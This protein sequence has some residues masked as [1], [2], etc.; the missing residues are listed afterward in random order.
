M[1]A[2]KVKKLDP[3]RP[4]V[5][6]AARILRVRIKELRSFAP[7]AL[8]PEAVTAQHDLRIAAKR[9]RYVLEVTGFCFG[10]SAA[11]AQRRAKELQGIL[12][13]MHDCDVMIPMV[14]AHLA[15]LRRRD[16]D[17]LR[18]RGGSEADLDPALARAA[19]HRTAYRGLD[20]LV[21]YLEARRSHLFERFTEFWAE[22]ERVG[23]WDRLDRAA[24]RQIELAKQRRRARREADEARKV[25]EDAE[26]AQREAR[27][28]A[29]KAQEELERTTLGPG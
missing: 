19:P 2:R 18:G 26:R 23:T 29:E 1:K 7:E 24:F 12:G 27:E 21:V 13:E 22:Q 14:E 6:N 17:A 16:A 25:L 20:V 8:D 3:D 10:R 11:T 5:E 4:L 28:R 9:L 15:D